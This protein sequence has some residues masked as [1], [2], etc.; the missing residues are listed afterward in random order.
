MNWFVK[1][2]DY[3]I[4]RNK[5]TNAHVAFPYRSRYLKGWPRRNATQ[6]TYLGATHYEILDGV[7]RPL[8][9]R[10]LKKVATC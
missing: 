4:L 3:N 8:A 6:A 5:R 2:M 7:S 1:T 10:L 9:R